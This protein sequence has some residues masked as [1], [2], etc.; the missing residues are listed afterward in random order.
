MV[1][2]IKIINDFPNPQNFHL[3]TEKRRNIIYQSFKMCIVLLLRY[4]RKKKNI[5]I[6]MNIYIYIYIYEYIYIYREREK[7][8]RYE[9]LN[10]ISR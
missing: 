1:S 7:R 6:Y 8:G 2:T 4:S 5:Y 3:L 9:N 10:S